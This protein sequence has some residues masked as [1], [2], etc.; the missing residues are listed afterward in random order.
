M[1][2]LSFRI[3]RWAI[4]LLVLVVLPF[5]L[6]P[7]PLARATGIRYAKPA[8]TGLGDCSSWDNACDLQTALNGSTVGDEI[9][10]GAGVHK[11]TTV[12]TEITATFQLKSDVAIYGGF[13]MTETQRDQRNITANITVLSGDIDGN[14]LTDPH[15]VVTDTH[16]ITGTNAY[17]VVTGSGVSTTAVLDGFTVTGGNA[18]SSSLNDS[19]G[20]MY[21]DSG[22][23][24]LNNI[25]FS[26]NAASAGGGMCNSNYS[27]PALNN[28]TFSGNA[29]SG[30]GGMYNS[31][32][33][34]PTLT[35]VTFSGNSATG[36]GGMDSG[37]G[38]PTL[39]NVTFTGNTAYLGGGIYTFRGSPSLNN[40]TFSGNTADIGG[41]MYSDGYPTLTNVTFSGNTAD[42][43]GGMFSQLGH[44]YIRNTILWGNSG[45]QITNV[46][47]IEII[48]DSVLQGNCPGFN[49]CMNI[50]TTDPLLGPLGDN[51][52]GTLTFALLPG[53]SAIDA[54][55]DTVC[56]GTDQRGV[57]R[58]Q[59]AHCDIGAFES[60]G[61]TLT[62][63]DGDEQT[64]LLNRA[65]AQPL[66]VS[67]ASANGEPVD[68]GQVVFAAP[69]SGSSVITPTQT[70]PTIGGV[71]LVNE[72]AN[73]IAGSYP[74]M[75]TASGA[76]T[77]TFVLTNTTNTLMAVS[78]SPNPSTFGQLVTF[79]ATVSAMA[80]DSGTPSGSVAFKDNGTT[81]PGCGAQELNGSGQAT[82]TTPALAAG[83]RNVS[84]EYGGDE[85]YTPNVATYP[86]IVIPARTTT[87]I[88]SSTNPSL[89]GDAVTF[90]VTVTSPYS[91]PSGTV[92]FFEVIAPAAS[93]RTQVLTTQSLVDGVV[94]F[95]V[96]S[97]TAGT[98]TMLATYNGD[99]NYIPSI[100]PQYT[101]MVNPL[102]LNALTINTVGNGNGTVLKSP[103]AISY[104]AGTVV[105]LTAVPSSTSTFAGWSGTIVTTTNPLVLTM[106]VDKA[107]TATFNTYHVYLPLVI[108]P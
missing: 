98:H 17:H 65:F 96:A 15:S 40:V 24:T 35:N 50:I 29:A 66:G 30:G 2:Q 107:V 73:N 3:G 93:Q 54:G 25:T 48:R 58:P 74:V 82:C 53:S 76:T 103:D 69:S 6:L 32:Y 28:V 27:S 84:A 77:I 7:I 37:N 70:I 106:D 108:K 5:A 75:V 18:N 14:D 55:N 23:P 83:T 42:I 101:Q 36:G 86:Q 4:T 64:A 88:T 91:T 46:G 49:T 41:G 56:P 39:N 31:N 71:V 67:V 87:I 12:D 99:A 34:S 97:F 47:A 102:H 100:S 95:T 60:R 19:G 20:G 57:A 105:T 44:H 45:G 38:S 21:N 104:T 94:T 72:I 61:F 68:G 11:P 78:A 33:S 26:G 80:P 79:S 90:T 1:S 8:A 9:W 59:G 13:A 51:G 89:A 85:V 62:K 63:S 16:Y 10:V 81:I 22:S 92:D 52:G 43:G